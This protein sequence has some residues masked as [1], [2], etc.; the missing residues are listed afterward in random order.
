MHFLFLHHPIKN[1]IDEPNE[2]TLVPLQNHEHNANEGSE[3]LDDALR[4]ED[5]PALYPEEN[6]MDG[7]S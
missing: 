5:M 2:H 7:E 1:L 6:T 3:F 4:M